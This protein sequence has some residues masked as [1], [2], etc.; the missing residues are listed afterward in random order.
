MYKCID[1]EHYYHCNSH[2]KTHVYTYIYSQ[3][4]LQHVS[5]GIVRDGEDVGWHLCLPPAPVHLHHRLGVDREHA[6]G[7]DGHTEQS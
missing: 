2:E 5:V 1:H 6:V 4:T 7:V 3:P